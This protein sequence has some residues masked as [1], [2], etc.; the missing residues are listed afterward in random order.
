M[1]SVIGQDPVIEDCLKQGAKDFVTKPI[2]TE[3]LLKVVKKALT[4]D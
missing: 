4:S 3:K 1:L 2:S